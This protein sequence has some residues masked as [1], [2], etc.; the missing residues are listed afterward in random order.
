MVQHRR[1]HKKKRVSPPRRAG[2]PAY[3]VLMALSTIIVML[4]CAYCPVSKRPAQAPGSIP[5]A[6]A[7]SLSSDQTEVP[8]RQRQGGA[9]T[10]LLAVS[11]QS[12][13]NVDTII[14]AP[15]DTEA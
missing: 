4:H 2:E 14:V 6:L 5:E 13:G 7:G 10:F 9:Y 11:G 3:R 1:I 8:S 12:S 15:Y